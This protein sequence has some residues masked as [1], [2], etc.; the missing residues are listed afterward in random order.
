MVAAALFGVLCS[1]IALKH[2]VGIAQG[3]LSEPSFCNISEAFN[4]DAV[5]AS[6]YATLGGL[7]VAGLGLIFFAAQ[8]L[9]GLWVLFQGEAAHATAGFGLWLA[10]LGLIPSAYLLYVMTVVLGTY[11]LTCLGMDAATLLMLFGWACYGRAGLAALKDRSAWVR[12]GSTLG[13][14][15]FVGIL[16][17]VNLR[18]ATGG[19]QVKPEVLREA[20]RAFQRQPQV[21]LAI[22]PQEHPVWGAPDAKVT[23]VEFSD[24]EC[25]HCQKAAF[26]IRPS[27]AEFRRHVRFVFVNNPLDQSCNDDI[28]HPAH[29]FACLAARAALCAGDVGRFWEY[30]DAVFKIQTKLS[31]ERLIG[32]AK[33]HGIEESAFVAC[34]DAPETDQRVRRDLEIGR[35][36]K[37][38]GTPTVYVNGRLL[39]IW[40]NAEFLRAVLNA[41]LSR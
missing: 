23:I 26:F 21:Q 8:A 37:I 14:L 11:C 30:H 35:S 18:S 38:S 25:P 33:T 16:F 1:A 2:Y 5:A 9:F 27:L 20:L 36:V 31:R 41:E 19:G 17:L 10:A 3:G 22:N 13:V 15:F 29:Q 34:L 32:L 28:K 24:F 12:H 4:C 6:S 39:R 7:P 40:Q